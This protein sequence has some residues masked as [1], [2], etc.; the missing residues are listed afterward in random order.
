M[1]VPRWIYSLRTYLACL[2]LIFALFCRDYEF[3]DDRI[4]WPLG[5]GILLIGII[6]RVWAQQ[7]V[8]YRIKVHKKL[9]TTGP[10]R[11]VRNPLCLGNLLIGV[12]ATVT[13]EL[14]WFTPVTAAWLILVYSLVVRH[15][16]DH[17]LGKYGDSCREYRSAVPRWLPKPSGMRRLQFVNEY[18][19]RAASIELRNLF[20]LVPFVL[21]ELFSA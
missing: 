5:M 11:F 4:I 19:R 13:S 2:P 12:G 3:E 6:L 15:E 1:T 8:H 21:K 20:I 17:L 10:Y 14:L 7:H 18:L 16:E 9:T